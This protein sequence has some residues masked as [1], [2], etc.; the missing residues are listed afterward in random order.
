MRVSECNCH[1]D[2]YEKYTY[3]YKKLKAAKAK[4]ALMNL[5]EEDA[6]VYKNKA[7]VAKVKSIKYLALSRQMKLKAMKVTKDDDDDRSVLI[8]TYT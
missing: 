6:E 3:Y 4:L 1:K 7:L 5:T 2:S 8:K